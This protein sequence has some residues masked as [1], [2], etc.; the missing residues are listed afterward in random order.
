M[1]D[2]L[3]STTFA[4]LVG[5]TFELQVE[6][7]DALLTLHLDGTTEHRPAPG[8]PRQQPFTLHFLGPG[9]DHLPQRIY[10]LVHPSAGRFE[11]FLIPRGPR[12]D[13]RQQYDAEFN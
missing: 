11:I 2:E 3:T 9:G 7:G 12:A 8:G 13:G 1:A 5:T 6:P 10:S 4:P